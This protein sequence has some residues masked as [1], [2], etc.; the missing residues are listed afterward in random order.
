MYLFSDV[1]HDFVNADW[2][3]HQLAVSQICSKTASQKRARELYRGK[4]LCTECTQLL[5][6]YL[7]FVLSIEITGEWRGK[8][9]TL[10]N[11][12]GYNL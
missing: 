11:H 5:P 10:T 2:K 9:A 8:A 3:G 1:P 6:E 4:Y 7:H 12:P